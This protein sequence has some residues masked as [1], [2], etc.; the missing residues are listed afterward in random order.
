MTLRG[1]GG[2][3]VAAGHWKGKKQQ[4]MSGGRDVKVRGAKKG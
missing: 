3:G 1:S 4:V 2:G